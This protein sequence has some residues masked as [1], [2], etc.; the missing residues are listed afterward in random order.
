M[1]FPLP[2][3]MVFPSRELAHAGRYFK[4]HCVSMIRVCVAWKSSGERLQKNPPGGAPGGKEGG[5]I[6]QGW[7]TGRKP[8][9]MRTSSVP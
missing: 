9:I 6:V 2:V 1:V 3:W 5:E 7:R 4:A 8:V